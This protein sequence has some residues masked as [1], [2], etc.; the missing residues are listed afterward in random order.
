MRSSRDRPFAVRSNVTARR[1]VGPLDDEVGPAPLAPPA[2]VDHIDAV[3]HR[4]TRGLAR[5]AFA[6]CAHCGAVTEQ[7][8]PRYKPRQL[9]LMFALQIRRR[10]AARRTGA[11]A[12][13]HPPAVTLTSRARATAPS[14]RAI[15]SAASS[16]RSRALTCC[17]DTPNRNPN[18][19]ADTKRNRAAHISHSRS[20]RASTP[21][22]RPRTSTHPSPT[23]C[24]PL[25]SSSQPSIPTM[26]RPDIQPG[27]AFPS[28]T[29][30]SP[31]ARPRP[32]TPSPG[33]GSTTRPT[34]LRSTRW[35]R[36][37]E[38][39]TGLAKPGG[40]GPS[41]RP[42]PSTVE[43]VGNAAGEGVAAR[44]PAVRSARAPLRRE[45]R[46]SEPRAGNASFSVVSVE[47]L[48]RCRRDHEAVLPLRPS[49]SVGWRRP[50]GAREP[51][52]AACPHHLTAAA[53]HSR[54]V[55]RY[56]VD[57]MTLE[58]AG[59]RLCAKRA[60]AGVAQLAGS[61]MRSG[62]HGARLP[63]ERF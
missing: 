50:R 11:S 39:T 63:I 7:F 61:C 30:A 2:A 58:G 49:R 59:L 1:W 13:R 48:G 53:G 57:P 38:P 3:A 40:T 22:Q 18:T 33:V 46:P 23:P 5:A 14:V 52:S 29:P 6:L 56:C 51:V 60:L 44:S 41:G 21:A 10:G 28:P 25:F 34:Q 31:A 55:L 42:T 12:A 15:K 54:S 9:Q 27:P 20:R 17:T 24:P 19:A 4:G 47:R 43:G 62:P 26:A 16:R 8:E 36:V 35:G 32:R 37:V 45:V